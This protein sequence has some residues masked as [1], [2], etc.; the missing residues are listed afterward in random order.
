MA[1]AN[2]A[3][4]SADYV[5]DT[6]QNTHWMNHFREDTLQSKLFSGHCKSHFEHSEVHTVLWTGHTE[7]WTVHTN[8]DQLL[9]F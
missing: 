8:K 5:V 9:I 4:D 6:L 3:E 7:L 1:S 2:V